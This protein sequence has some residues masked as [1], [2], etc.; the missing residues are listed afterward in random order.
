MTETE[1]KHLKW[2]KPEISVGTIL[3]I[4]AFIVSVTL[5]YAT[6]DKTNAVQDKIMEENRNR[7]EIGLERERALTRDSVREVKNQ[8]QM[9]RAEMRRQFDKLNDKLD[10][11][12]AE[13]AK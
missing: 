8:A 2:F 6:L 10:K 3:T 12:I 1:N 13:K 5:S 7:I 9:D 11:L 4:A